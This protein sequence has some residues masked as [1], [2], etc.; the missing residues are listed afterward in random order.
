ML[1]FIGFY[2]WAFLSEPVLEY[3]FGKGAMLPF[4][5]G[6]LLGFGVGGV[7]VLFIIREEVEK[8]VEYINRQV[9]E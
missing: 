8:L 1:F 2:I 6:L 9:D 4:T 7:Y 3:Y 5:V